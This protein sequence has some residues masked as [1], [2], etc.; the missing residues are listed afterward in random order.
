MLEECAKAMEVGGFLVIETRSVNDPLC[1]DGTAVE[2]EEN[3]QLSA[4]NRDS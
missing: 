3:A 4:T 2:G 1:R